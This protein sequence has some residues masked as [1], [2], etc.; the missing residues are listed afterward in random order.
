MR[1]LARVESSFQ[2][3]R[4]YPSLIRIGPAAE[5]VTLRIWGPSNT[6]SFLYLSVSLKM[7]S[8]GISNSHR[9]CIWRPSHVG[10]E[11]G[12]LIDTSIHKI[13]GSPRSSNRQEKENGNN[14]GGCR[15]CHGRLIPVRP[16]GHPQSMPLSNLLCFLD[17]STRCGHRSL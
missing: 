17:S 14:G 9:L 13:K 7:E 5:A 4:Q 15:N 10:V 1:Y 8:M 3:V 16:L 11:R 12:F 2:W 6:V